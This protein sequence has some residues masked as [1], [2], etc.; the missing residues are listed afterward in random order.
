MAIFPCGIHFGKYEQERAYLHTKPQRVVFFLFMVFLLFIPYLFSSQIISFLSIATIMLIAVVGLQIT[1]GFAGQINLGQSAFMGV[2]AFTTAYFAN[3]YDLP[4]WLS[5]PAGGVGAAMAGS[6]FALPALRVKGFYLALTTVAA[7]VLFPLIIV[8][9]PYK[10]CGGPSGVMLEA[11]TIG[12]FKVG[13]ET[14][15]YYFVVFFAV[16]MLFFAFNL[17]RT[18]VGRALMAIRDRD[19]AAEI[20][21]YNLFFYKMLAFFIGAFYAGI[22]G[23]L[24]A[25]YVRFISADHF[26]LYYS[27]WFLGMLVVGGMGNILGAIL[28]TFFLR[29]V[30]EL[31]TNMAPVLA[32]RFESVGGAELWFSCI[33]IFLGGIIIIFLIFEPKGLA[34]RWNI[35]KLS[36]RIWPFPYI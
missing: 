11:A 28:G 17:V 24:W 18:R 31:M 7:Q 20:I 9:L 33:N 1:T 14:R 25:Y 30:Q 27:I 2:G 4:F 15:L 8:S 19:I 35:I 32:G 6:M 21:G 16:I 34:H 13:T 22:A 26:T 12:N 3:H 29:A 10:W 36:F 23:G 5:I